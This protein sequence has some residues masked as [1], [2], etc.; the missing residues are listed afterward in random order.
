MKT[1]NNEFWSKVDQV[2]AER[3]A[4]AV[5]VVDEQIVAQR[6]SSMPP[7]I[8]SPRFENGF[9]VG[10]TEEIDDEAQ[11]AVADVLQNLKLKKAKIQSFLSKK[12]E[13]AKKMMGLSITPLAILPEEVW[14]GLVKKAGLFRFEN[15]QQDGKVPAQKISAGIEPIIF[16][17]FF[18]VVLIFDLLFK[19]SFL[20]SALIMSF[21]FFML[22]ALSGEEREKK[23]RKIQHFLGWT[24][25][26]ASTIIGGRVWFG[27]F[28]QP[29]LIE[30]VLEI[31]LTAICGLALLIGSCF[32]AL[33]LSE[34]LE[35]VG[36]DS[37]K[38]N[39]YYCTIM[40][41]WVLRKKIW[42]ER[43]DQGED[44]IW[45]YFPEPRQDF[46][47]ILVKAKNLMYKICVAAEGR[48][49][50]FDRQEVASTKPIDPI[51]YIKIDGMVVVLGQFGNFPKERKLIQW[52]REQEP[53][54]IFN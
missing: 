27:F 17:M 7:K 34:L 24:G 50:N 40:P 44:L 25:A 52:I 10:Y 41:K 47:D 38:I 26:G 16:V 35:F 20:S 9:L 5:E 11:Q 8:K 45:V 53:N 18:P 4:V 31:L 51:I 13:L 36:L 22:N 43:I 33:I 42:P 14:K 28:K 21:I 12:M 54:L 32:I 30:W 49:I 23:S 6:K 46:K 2:V 37:K 48:A 1:A 39:K 15:F 29:G 3:A 19:L